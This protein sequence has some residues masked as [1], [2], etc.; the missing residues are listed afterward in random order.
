MGLG[1][2]VNKTLTP[3][4]LQLSRSTRH[5]P[6]EQAGNTYDLT[7]TDLEGM[8]R[9]TRKVLNL[10]NYTKQS[11]S[12]YSA[13]RFE[14]AY[15]T[16]EL[17]GRVFEG[18][19]NPAERLTDVPFDF[20]DARVLDIGCNQGGMLFHLGPT[21]KH[22]IGIDYDYRMINAANR[23]RILQQ[24]HNLSFFVFDLEQENLELLDNFLQDSEVDV[25]FLLSICMW[26]INWHEVIDY[27][28]RVA[29]HLLFESNGTPVQ[30]DEQ[31]A[32]LRQK[33]GTVQKIRDASDDDPSNR[34]RRLFFCSG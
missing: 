24:T 27:A 20:T 26:I 19:R 9:D 30:Q 33:Y 31:V 10:L 17:E 12:R 21:I 16:I 13:S 18:Q 32:Y 28:Y 11:G 3:L 14:S 7:P 23:V 15:H 8:S 25:A 22:G 4:G 5:R 34:N 29:D 2:I 6:N 1:S